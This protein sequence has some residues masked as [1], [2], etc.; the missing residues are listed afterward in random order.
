MNRL[1]MQH[2]YEVAA[3]YS[4]SAV[5]A[6]TLA[7]LAVRPD[8]YHAV[9]ATCQMLAPDQFNVRQMA[10]YQQG[11]TLAGG[12][13]GYLDLLCVLRA[14]SVVQQPRRYLEIGVRRGRS[15]CVV[16]SATPGVDIYACDMWQIG[17]AGSEN[18]GPDF[19]SGELDKIG[20]RGHRVYLNGDSRTELPDLFRRDPDLRFDLITVDGDHSI[21][22]AWADLENVVKR[23]ETGGV[24]VFD[25]CAN[26]YCPGLDEVWRKFLRKHPELQG[27][28]YDEL[29]PGVGFALRL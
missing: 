28:T 22:G 7:R 2:E 5:S 6:S 25:D 15:S 23:L 1:L 10:L 13:W 27:Y 19:V 16:A 17:Y 24:L 18:P 29:P 26:P 8:T 12:D 20:H 11:L 9:L 4:R 21:K 14:T 3:S